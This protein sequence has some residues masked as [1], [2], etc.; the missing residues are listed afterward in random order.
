MTFPETRLDT[1]QQLNSI[2]TGHGSPYGPFEGP[3][4]FFI[5]GISSN[6][7]GSGIG[8]LSSLLSPLDSLFLA[9]VIVGVSGIMH[10][11]YSRTEPLN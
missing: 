11:L 3:A 2:A 4:I 1:R 5:L 9:E 7:P 6:M 10:T 8:S